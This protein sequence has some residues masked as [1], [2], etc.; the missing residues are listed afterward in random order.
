[1]LSF[2]K[3]PSDLFEDLASIEHAFV[4]TKVKIN[5]ID[6]IVAVYAVA[7]KSLFLILTMEES[8]RAEDPELEHLDEVKGKLRRHSGGKQDHLAVKAELVLNAFTGQCYACEKKGHWANQCPNQGANKLEM[9]SMSKNFMGHTNTVV[10]KDTRNRA[11]GNCWRMQKKGLV[12][13]SQRWN[14]PM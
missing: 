11:V 6:L 10:A 12:D 2:E 1:M 7:T 5:E 8:I 9:R 3:D 4:Q 13:T 14:M